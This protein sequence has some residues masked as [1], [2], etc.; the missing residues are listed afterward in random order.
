MA[1]DEI[2]VA[3][4][5]LF[6]S[7]AVQTLFEML[8]VQDVLTNADIVNVLVKTRKMATASG[9]PVGAAAAQMAYA[10][11]R[12]FREKAREDGSAE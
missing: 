2:D 3:A 6:A 7:L 5:G 4:T 12:P 10:L 9:G 8:V 1:E 11:D